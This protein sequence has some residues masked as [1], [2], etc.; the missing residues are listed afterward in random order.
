MSQA[1]RTLVA[2]ACL[3]AALALPVRAWRPVTQGRAPT[4]SIKV[5]SLLTKAEVKKHL[6]WAVFLD[7]M[8]PEETPIGN[9]GSSCNY[10]SVDVQV[11][12]FQRGTIDALRKKGGLESVTGIGD[13]AYFHNNANRYAELYVRVGD[14]M[15]TLQGN[16][17]AGGIDAVK[18]GVL[19]LARAYV[20]KLR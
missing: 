11:L 7:Q 19:S 15:L 12:T 8:D 5:C 18:P 20:E 14:R 13:E 2:A 3:V 16:V 4:G 6:P 10:P 1:T 9:S 17:S